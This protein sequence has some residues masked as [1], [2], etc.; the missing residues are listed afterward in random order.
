VNTSSLRTDLALIAQWI[1]PHSEV[2]D[3]GCGNGALLVHLRQHH[4]VTGY[5]IEID[6][7]NVV[8]CI[9]AGVNVIHGDVDQG[10]LDFA[11]NTFD[12]VVMTQTLQAMRRP[13]KAL[14]EMLRVGKESI[15]TFPNFGHWRARY[16]Y[17]MRGR[18][19]LTRALPNE[20]YDTPNIHLCT[21]W[22]FEALCKTLG[23]RILQRRVVDPTHRTSRGMK[24]LPNLFGE[25]ALYRLG[26]QA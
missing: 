3:L 5:G 2:L 17:G 26:K 25:L 11:D 9:Q 24:L 23:L 19:P 12:Y 14:L 20:W 1:H 18:M 15:V 7:D 10:L 16:H 6:D 4:Q 13:D 21:L 22:D 8:R